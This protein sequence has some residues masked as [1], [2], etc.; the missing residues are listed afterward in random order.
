M[1][2]ERLDTDRTTWV[3]VCRD[4]GK[5]SHAVICNCCEAEM[6][7]AGPARPRDW[8]ACVSVGLCEDCATGAGHNPRGWV[9][10]H[11]PPWSSPHRSD[12]FWP[13]VARIPVGTVRE[14]EYDPRFYGPDG[15]KVIT[16]RWGDEVLPSHVDPDLCLT[17][18][19]YNDE[20]MADWEGCEER[21]EQGGRDGC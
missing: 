8:P 19:R 12:I 15:P 6:M 11:H 2:E 10:P 9:G 13:C 7:T 16:S 4:C 17:T 5:T 21:I 18:V 1:S 14:Y 20:A 3:E